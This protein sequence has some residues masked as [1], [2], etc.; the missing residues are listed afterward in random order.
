M[1]SVIGYRVVFQIITFYNKHMNAFGEK[2]EMFI[3]SSCG[4]L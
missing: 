1:Q 3:H 4:S 2:M